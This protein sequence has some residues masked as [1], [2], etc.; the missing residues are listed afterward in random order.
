MI[1]TQAKASC[2][3]GVVCE[4]RKY[5][6]HTSGLFALDGRYQVQA[7]NSWQLQV[8]QNDIRPAC[9][10]HLNPLNSVLGAAHDFCRTALVN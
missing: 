8:E 5:D 4:A 6:Q 1:G 3:C 2:S 7:A 9:Y 10:Q